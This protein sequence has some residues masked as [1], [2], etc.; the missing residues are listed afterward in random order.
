MRHNAECVT[1]NTNGGFTRNSA[2]F[3]ARGQDAFLV[4]RRSRDRAHLVELEMDF[5]AGARAGENEQVPDCFCVTKEFWGGRVATI[6]ILLVKLKQ[7]LHKLKE[8]IGTLL[9]DYLLYFAKTILPYIF[10]LN[11]CSNFFPEPAAWTRASQEWTGST[12]LDTSTAYMVRSGA[13]EPRP[14]KPNC[15]SGSP[16]LVWLRLRITAL[17]L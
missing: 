3:W 9:K 7:L 10:Y 14:Q 6:L 15:V 2:P 13:L 5:F 12:V 16:K 1:A 11:L 4:I 8:K 17:D